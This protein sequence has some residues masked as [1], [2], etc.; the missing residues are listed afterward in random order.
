MTHYIDYL[1]SKNK[2]KK[3]RKHFES[4]KEAF[5]WILKTFDKMDIDLIIHV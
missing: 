4:Y 5:N 2:F 3:T 1:D